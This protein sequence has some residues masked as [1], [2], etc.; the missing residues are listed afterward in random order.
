VGA[1]ACEDVVAIVSNALRQS[2][3]EPSRHELTDE[4]WRLIQPLL[5]PH[6]P[7]GRGRRDDRQV[8]NGMFFILRTG[9]PWRDLPRRFGPWKTVYNRFNQWRGSRAI[10]GIME[11]LLKLLE[12]RGEI[13]WDLWCVDGSSIRAARCAAGAVKK[14]GPPTS[15]QTM[16][17]VA[18]EVVSARSS[19]S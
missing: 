3:T 4:D 6:A 14:G 12:E 9:C 1:V 13:D 10:D 7:R 15:R 16:R 11:G 18:R 8:L 17:S 19:I 5:P 2:S